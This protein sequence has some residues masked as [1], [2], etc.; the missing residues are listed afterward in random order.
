MA[1]IG[2]KFKTSQ[3]CE[4]S[5]TYDW[6]GYVD[7][8]QTPAPTYEEKR[9]PLESGETFPPIRSCDKSCWWKL[10]AYA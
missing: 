10:S 1:R 4:T 5:G 6:D 9:I 8:T 2:D 7:G 3:T